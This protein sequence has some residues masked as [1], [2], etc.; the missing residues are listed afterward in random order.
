[1]K[2]I[3]EL[4]YEIHEKNRKRFGDSE[5]CADKDR[6]EITEALLAELAKEK[7]ADIA[8]HLSCTYDVMSREYII[9]LSL[10]NSFCPATNY[11]RRADVAGQEYEDGGEGNGTR[12]KLKEARKKAGMTQKQVSEYLGI[13][14]RSYQRAESGHCSLRHSHWDALEDLFKVHQRVL[15]ERTKF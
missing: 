3:I 4:A 12:E 5:A 13:D 1:M 8:S 14:I 10:P 11:Y 7:S 15:R 6:E 2:D 9:V